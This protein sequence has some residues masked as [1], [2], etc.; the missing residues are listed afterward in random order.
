MPVIRTCT[1]F[2]PEI[3]RASKTQVLQRLNN[4]TKQQEIIGRKAIVYLQH[5]LYTEIIDL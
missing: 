2:E 5:L 4:T 3:K 1:V